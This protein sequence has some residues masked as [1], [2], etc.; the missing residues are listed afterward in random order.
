MSAPRVFIYVQHL[1]GIGH[2]VRANRIA[3]ALVDEGF[4]VTMATG[5]L[6]VQG[7]PGPG[8]RAITLPAVK[9][10]SGGFSA[11]EDENGGPV[12]DAFK[13][14]RRDGLIVALQNFKPDAVIVETFPFGRRA[15]RFE[16]LPFLDATLSLT[17]RPLIACSVRDILQQHHKPGRAEETLGTIDRYFDKVLVHGDPKLATFG[18]TFPLANS[19]ENKILYTGLVAGPHPA[20]PAEHYDIVISAGGGAV[21]RELVTAAAQMSGQLDKSLR[22]CLITGPN[23]PPTELASLTAES[24]PNLKIFSFRGDF[25]NLL[26][27]ARLSI[28]QAG[29]NTVCDILRA[30]CRSL[31]IPF[32]KDGETEQTLRSLR[33]EKLGLARVLSEDELDA[34]TLTRAVQNAIGESA[35]LPHGFNLEGANQTAALIR[36]LM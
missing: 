17:R 3:L 7:F 27:G 26:V 21:G 35:P 30:G 31:L 16:L 18:E 14:I 33:L 28:S 15:M 11:L 22:C 32:A 34:S 10:G 9:A 29:Y 23:L 25:P 6:P 8:I 24:G 12:D 36:S 13:Q 4:D 5:G 19:L 1:L 20:P 2:L